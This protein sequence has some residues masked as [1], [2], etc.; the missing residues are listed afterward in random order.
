M[1]AQGDTRPLQRASKGP[2]G[3]FR[4]AWELCEDWSGGWPSRRPSAPAGI[5]WSA[6]GGDP[7]YTVVR[8]TEKVFSHANQTWNKNSWSCSDSWKFE[9][10]SFSWADNHLCSRGWAG[11]AWSPGAYLLL[12]KPSKIVPRQHAQEKKKG[13]KIKMYLI[14]IIKVQFFHLQEF[15][16]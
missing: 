1:L 9:Q 11:F 13:K 2:T 5:H 16:F 14:M 4:H 12:L 6:Q 10:F 7:L 15:T 8:I 3:L